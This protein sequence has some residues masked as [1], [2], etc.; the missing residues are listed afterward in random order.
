MFSISD[1]A[2]AASSGNVAHQD[3]DFAQAGQLRCADSALARDHLV[4]RQFCVG[5]VAGGRMSAIGVTTRRTK[6]GCMIPCALM[7]SASS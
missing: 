7:L 6:T 4:A 2:A 3:R 5:A 1:M